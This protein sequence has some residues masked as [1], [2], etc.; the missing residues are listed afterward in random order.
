MTS[1]DRDAPRLFELIVEFQTTHGELTLDRLPAQHLAEWLLSHGVSVAS[2]G[3]P[4]PEPNTCP[5]LTNDE[6]P[7]HWGARCG[8][9]FCTYEEMAAHERKHA[10]V[11]G[12]SSSPTGGVGTMSEPSA[13]ELARRDRE[14]QDHQPGGQHSS[15]L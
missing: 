1:A 4:A 13:D 6:K 7:N 15:W 9:D 2:L 14:L 5:L 8:T 10:D 11:R 12:S 3:T